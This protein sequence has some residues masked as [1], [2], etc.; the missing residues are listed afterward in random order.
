[1]FETLV[2]DDEWQPYPFKKIGY[3]Y[4]RDESRAKRERVQAYS[5]V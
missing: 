4:A 2:K 5:I 3:I 1:V